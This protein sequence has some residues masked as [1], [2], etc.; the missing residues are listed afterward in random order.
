MKQEDDFNDPLNEEIKN[1]WEDIVQSDSDRLRNMENQVLSRIN[2]RN[3]LNPL[4][5]IGKLTGKL[6]VWYHQFTAAQRYAIVGSVVTATLIGVL[7]G[8]FI[9]PARTPNQTV[10]VFRLRA[11]S[12]DK[13]E[14]AG[15]FSGFKPIEMSDKDGDGVWTVKLKLN[16]GK[17]EYYYLLNG[18]DKPDSYPRADEVVR[19]WDNSK[20]GIIYIGEGNQ[21]NTDNK[22]SA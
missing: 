2:T 12:A 1:E 16:E 19:D 9:L 5:W 10:T 6:S 11:A 18:S 21:D 8:R 13:V 20:N 4:L 14:L 22:T 15:E 3:N 7:F 17:Y